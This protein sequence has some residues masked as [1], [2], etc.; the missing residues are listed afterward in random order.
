MTVSGKFKSG[1][2][3]NVVVLFLK[4]GNIAIH[5]DD[6]VLCVLDE[7]LIL[8][9]AHVLCDPDGSISIS[10][11][12]RIYDIWYGKY[13][14]WADCPFGDFEELISFQSEDFF[15]KFKERMGKIQDKYLEDEETFFRVKIGNFRWWPFRFSKW[16]KRGVKVPKER[17]YELKESP[18]VSLIIFQGN[19]VFAN[20]FEPK[21]ND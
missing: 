2:Y 6:D 3:K 18:L 10:G 8:R 20:G 17:Y 7:T 13:N 12:R 5:C 9:D 21:V 1:Y 14:S 19:V 16:E 15:E 11:N 4:N